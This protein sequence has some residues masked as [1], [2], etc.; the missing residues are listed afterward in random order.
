MWGIKYDAPG[1]QYWKNLYSEF[2]FHLSYAWVLLFLF[3]FQCC[4]KYHYNGCH[5]CWDF[6]SSFYM[7][8]SVL[9]HQFQ[10]SNHKQEIHLTVR[11][12]IEYSILFTR[13]QFL[14]SRTYYPF[15]NS[16][17]LS[18]TWSSNT[19][20]N[21]IFEMIKTR[22]IFNI[23]VEFSISV[24]KVLHNILRAHF[25]VYS[26]TDYPI[27]DLSNIYLTQAAGHIKFYY[28]NHFS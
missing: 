14:K 9:V 12:C 20:I 25:W 19:L 28:Y 18:S 24:S 2:S 6:L 5:L 7:I 8:V 22:A 26:A 21:G 15:I 13:L 16:F 3:V 4:W 27:L 23:I 11:N 17:Y 10:N 1:F